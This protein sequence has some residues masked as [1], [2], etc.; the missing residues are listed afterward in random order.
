MSTIE[1]KILAVDDNSI[2]I[3]LLGRTLT[4]NN[5]G[6]LTASSGKEAIEVKSSL[7]FFSK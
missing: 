3:K 6:V 2:N 4:N 5:F 1:H 7:P